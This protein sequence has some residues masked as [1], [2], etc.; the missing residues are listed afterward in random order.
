MISLYYVGLDLGTI[1]IWR[2]KSLKVR[3]NDFEDKVHF[4]QA[5]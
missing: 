5:L 1:T 4:F 2:L 3:L